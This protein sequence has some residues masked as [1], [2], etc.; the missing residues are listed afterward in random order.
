MNSNKSIFIKDGYFCLIERDRYESIERF[1]ERGW[2]IVSIS[3]KT[4]EELDEAIRLS[5]IWANIKFNKCVYNKF[6]MNKIN[7]FVDISKT[8]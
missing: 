2:F 8:V 6:L 4:D 5:R 3:P 7:Y 1:N